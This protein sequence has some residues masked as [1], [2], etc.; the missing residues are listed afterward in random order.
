MAIERKFVEE[1]QKRVLLKEFLTKESE[2]AGFGGLKIQRTPMGTLITMQIERPGL[3]IGRGGKRIKELTETIEK[4]F[5]IEN[6][7]IEI[8]EVGNQVALNAHLMA[9][10][11]ASALERGWH[12]RRV[13]HST[14]RRIME[15]G[16]RGCQ[17]IISGKLT[18]ARH[19][20]EKFTMGYVKYCGEVANEVMEEGMAIAKTKPGV[21]G[22]KVRIMRPDAKL[23]DEVEIIEEG[24][25]EMRKA[26]ERE[27]IEKE[28]MLERLEKIDVG[29]IPGIPSNVVSA[30]KKAGVKNARELYE[31]EIDDLVEIKGIGIKRAEQLKEAIKEVLKR[32]ESEGNQGNE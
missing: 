19:R 29:D 9:Q 22:V 14:V 31:M 26:I 12:F 3:I 2:R 5:G 10:K 13:G 20:T 4:K 11:V 7:Q 8:E 16:A 6:P 21:I 30:I 1:N 27:R 25:E 23:P 15:A 24:K 18:G 17:V 28:E 32:N